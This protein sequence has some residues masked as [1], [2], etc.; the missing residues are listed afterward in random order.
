[1]NTNRP[2][3]NWLFRLLCLVS[4]LLPN[5]TARA[6]FTTGATEN[7]QDS[8]DWLTWNGNFQRT[9]YVDDT[10]K[11]PVG[12][13]L[14]TKWKIFLGERIEVEVEPLVAGDLVYVAVMN[15]KLYA[16]DRKTGVT[17]WVFEALSLITNTPSIIL[18]KDFSA[19]Y[20]G[21]TSGDFFAV[22]ALNGS[23]IWQIKLNGAVLSSPSI[24][25]GQVLVGSLDHSFYA[26]DMY[27]GE[28]VWQFSAD[29]PISSTSAVMMRGD[30]D[31]FLV[32]FSSGNNIAYALD[33]NGNLVWQQSMAGT[34][35]KRNTIVVSHGVAIF[36]T[37]KA[38][39][40]YSEELTNPPE[41]L[42]GQPADPET[43]LNAWA[44]YYQVH[45][46]RRTLYFFD[47]LTG[48][49]LW[50]PEIDLARYA[51]LYIPYWGLISPV[52]N[53]QGFAYFPASGSGGD[54]AL[55][56]DMRLWEIDL[57]TGA[58]AQVASQDQFAPRFDEV[59]RPTL[60]GNSYY[61]TISEDISLF[62]LKTKQNNTNLFGN[63]FMNHRLP[64]EFAEVETNRLFGGFAEY[65][66]RFGGS[67][68]T[69]FA[70]AVDAISPLVI[71][72]SDAFVISWGH[73]SALSTQPGA[74][75][76]DYGVADFAELPANPISPSA[77]RDEVEQT[78]QDFLQ[79]GA[80]PSPQSRMW[81]WMKMDMGTFWH[82][83]EWVS[84]L[85]RALP[86]L[87]PATQKQLNEFLK[88]YLVS[89]L[90]NPA[91]YEYRQACLDFDQN[92][93]LD[94]C[95]SL[96]GIQATWYWSNP[97][98]VSERIIALD[99][100][101][102][103]T[104]DW[105]LIKQNWAFIVQQLEQLESYWNEANGIYI[106]ETWHAGPFLPDL[107]IRMLTSVMRMSN[108]VGDEDTYIRFSQK[109]DQLK[110]TRMEL[111]AYSSQLDERANPIDLTADYYPY[112][113]DLS[114]FAL[115]PQVYEVSLNDARELVGIYQSAGHDV[116]PIF[117]V[118][119]HPVFPDSDIYQD[120][121]FQNV[122]NQNIHAIEAFFPFWYLGDYAHASPINGNEDDSINPTLAADIFQAKAYILQ[123]PYDELARM[124]PLPYAGGNGKIDLYR[125]QN[126]V[127][128]LKANIPADE[129]GD[130][131]VDLDD[132]Y[133]A[134]GMDRTRY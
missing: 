93:V 61:Q 122:V 109:L 128:L 62:N 96:G 94:P 40:E 125:V 90:L 34:F 133:I 116:Y 39:G 10:L 35:T 14:Y 56:H 24:A 17:R 58:Y 32:F 91:Y 107:Q 55:D 60:A 6:E 84:T 13:R 114:T 115:T 65:F 2:Y 87:T 71:S 36:T 41:E 30:S 25:G 16:L 1:M 50:Q 31:D 132:F 108:Q 46:R 12:G 75:N 54:H 33:A 88:D 110:P 106:F 113:S 51:P 105:D 95:E 43:V 118:G 82:A 52:V 53:P 103:A 77:A 123:T 83:G 59:G 7:F 20:F 124:V 111:L 100:Y 21:T 38:G 78:I 127:A 27:T 28:I 72:G 66:T 134:R 15:G 42:Q 112:L 49:D 76:I 102:N 79:S 126:L 48:K 63:G 120:A 23:V 5:I 81:A 29:G 119:F 97:N 22:N 69:G 57:K 47:A 121:R 99:D 80:Q 85:S 11:I 131:K 3:K 9:S 70:G 64:V 37:R 89:D 130:G 98:L 74:V 73:I 4:L 8:T 45:P 92:T 68:Q 19:V 101:A 44:R 86:Y 129:N 117:L 104:G 67:T 18:E 26:L